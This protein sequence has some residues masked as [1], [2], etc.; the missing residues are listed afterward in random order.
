MATLQQLCSY[1]K[2]I[3]EDLG[4]IVAQ[5]LRVSLS[6]GCVFAFLFAAFFEKVTRVLHP[7]A[8]VVL[9]T[10]C[11]G[12]FLAACGTIA[13]EGVDFVR[14]T[15]L[16]EWKDEECPVKPI[17]A[18]ISTPSKL[19]M[20]FGNNLAII[21]LTFLAI[22]RLVATL[23]AKSY[24]RKNS[25]LIGWILSFFALCG[26]VLSVAV[27]TVK[28][29][30]YQLVAVSLIPDPAA[31]DV[32]QKVLFLMLGLEVINAVLFFAIYR[33]NQRWQGRLNVNG[34]SLA[35]KYQIKENVNFCAVLT[36]LA[37]LHCLM[38]V[39]TCA[40]LF[41]FMCFTRSPH[42]LYSISIM[43]DIIVVYD[44]LL[45][46]LLMYKTIWNRQ[47]LNEALHRFFQGNQVVSI[48]PSEMDNHFQLLKNMFDEGPTGR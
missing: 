15:F 28:I 24:E 30:F 4:V 18:Y 44:F 43:A 13:A 11:V 14:H 2:E 34:A 22:E 7:N 37:A 46:L 48:P 10:H 47:K 35:H 33:I 32:A 45:P 23:R 36:P 12:V 8:R 27:I 29:N 19:L 6:I 26:A 40:T 5:A 1:A 25:S 38:T 16:K 21:S 9:K 17:S 20:V 41:T 39:F 31:I 3:S 42:S